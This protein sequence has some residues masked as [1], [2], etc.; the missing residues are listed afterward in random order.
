M[1][2]KIIISLVLLMV[3]FNN[4]AF[5]NFALIHPDNYNIRISNI[6]EEITKIELLAVSDVNPSE[7]FEYESVKE[8][9]YYYIYEDM[10]HASKIHIWNE[11]DI[12]YDNDRKTRGHL[13]SDDSEYV[14]VNERELRVYDL[15]E[16]DEN[17]YVILRFKEDPYYN[18]LNEI[19]YYNT[20]CDSNREFFFIRKINKV[21]N[22]ESFKLRNDSFELE[23]KDIERYNIDYNLHSPE[24]CIRLYN[25]N[26]DYKDVFVGDNEYS[27]SSHLHKIKRISRTFDYE[28][29]KQL[30]GGE[31]ASFSMNLIYIVFNIG[32]ALLLTIIVEISVADKMKIFN[33][34]TIIIVNTLTQ[35]LLHSLVFIPQILVG[36]SI[37]SLMVTKINSVVK[38]IAGHETTG[39]IVVLIPVTILELLI[40]FIEFVAYRIFIKNESKKKLFKYAFLANL[41]SYILSI[42]FYVCEV[43]F[44]WI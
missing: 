23:I 4:Y 21:I 1:K 32:I 7:V 3:I 34:K 43:I 9:G 31:S 26:G 29:G 14:Y 19:Y 20:Y 33:H 6:D 22:I 39:I 30:S 15:T 27:S 35:L 28:T 40:V 38:L 36:N 12:V 17:K 37:V 18:G 10:N 2:K 8:Y 13:K 5:A 24:F 41:Y 25:N 11:D 16:Y 42:I 44:A